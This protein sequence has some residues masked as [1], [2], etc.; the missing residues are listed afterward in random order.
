MAFLNIIIQFFILI[1]IYV[2][3]ATPPAIFYA[4]I[5]DSKLLHLHKTDESI[6]LQR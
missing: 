5:V 4:D 6:H 2:K 3:C 1:H